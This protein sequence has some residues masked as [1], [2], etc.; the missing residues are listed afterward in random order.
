MPQKLADCMSSWGAWVMSGWVRALLV[1]VGVL[2]GLGGSVAAQV[3]GV[4]LESNRF[5]VRTWGMS[6]GL[7]AP[8]VTAL[9]QTA[10]G[11]IWAASG[12]GLAR[13]DGSRFTVFGSGLVPAP[14]L[15]ATALAGGF[16]DRLWVGRGDGGVTAVDGKEIREVLGAGTVPGGVVRLVEDNR[17]RLW[18][19]GGDG[20]VSVL[21][22]GVLDACSRRWSGADGG[23]KFRVLP[24][25]Q[26]GVLI[27]SSG[28]LWKGAPGPLVPHIPLAGSP[29]AWLCASTEAWRHEGGMVY[30]VSPGSRPE[31]MTNANPPGWCP[32][33]LKMGMA[34]SDGILWVG[35][36]CEGLLAFL[37]DGTRDKLATSTGLGGV[38]VL[39]MMSDRNGHLWVG[40]ENGGLSRI[41]PAIFTRW[42]SR[43]NIRCTEVSSL[44]LMADGVVAAACGDLGVFSLVNA[45]AQPVLRATDGD[46]VIP[47]TTIAPR[48]RGELF[49]GTASDGL[50]Y[51][52]ED[53]AKG[54][55]L[56]PEL[57]APINV[58]LP[59]PDGSILVG[60]KA[61]VPLLEASSGG[62]R[63]IAFKDG[64]SDVR[65]LRRMDDGWLW[66][67]TEEDGLF[68]WKDG[69][70]EAVQAT[71]GG[72]PLGIRSIIP[73][74]DAI[75]VVTART[76]LWRHHGSDLRQCRKSDGLPSDEIIAMVPDRSGAF[77]CSAQ[78][79]FFRIEAEE[80][81]RWFDEGG[82]FPEVTVF[83]ESDGIGGQMGYGKTHQA[84]VSSPDGSL[85]FTS[86][87]GVVQIH[88]EL[89]RRTVP[90]GNII[91]EDVRLNGDVGI[92]GSQVAGQLHR[93]E[94]HFTIPGA[95]HPDGARYEVRLTPF[96]K[97]W[98]PLGAQRSVDYQHLRHGDYVFEVRGADRF[99]QTAGGAQFPFTVLAPVWLRPW[100]WVLSGGVLAGVIHS[101]M[102]TAYLRRMRRLREEVAIAAARQEE[103]ARIAR[104]MHDQLGAGL[105]ELVIIGDELRRGNT[106]SGGPERVASCAREL[107]DEMNDSIWAINPRNDYWHNTVGYLSRTIEEMGRRAGMEVRVNSS[108]GDQDCVLSSSLRQHLLLA[109]REA[110]TNAIRHASATELH[111]SMEHQGCAVE[112]RVEDNGQ[113]FP[114][115]GPQETGNGLRNMRQ[116]MQE[117]GGVVQFGRSSHGGAM[118]TLHV[119]APKVTAVEQ[120]SGISLN[121]PLMN[122]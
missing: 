31:P 105:A 70:A 4:P 103:R 34:G 114:E 16:S 79:G 19:E 108:A 111:V 118:V 98:V 46:R 51:C 10:D 59:G 1:V 101:F 115:G 73:H 52:R 60:R 28:G 91:I 38:N 116:R 107:V 88:P 84:A 42:D 29:D 11:Y 76:G 6:E 100:F 75:W 25:G 83:G 36:V 45:Y 113:G 33:H 119:P 17:G 64:A 15:Q 55:F 57:K 82:S 106:D 14:L 96:D 26:G 18:I 2:V 47:F 37:P 65:A 50:L 102:R 74:D 85:W 62:S 3:A 112:I 53:K 32:R 49:G 22:N 80:L 40:I 30:R 69:T 81:A 99:G 5:L 48:E 77:W 71:G 58:L 20:A 68:R 87:I 63:V 23:Q 12:Q 92:A 72:V 8:S 41:Q 13:F 21:E 110:V 86:S 39:A 61:E 24:D 90:P 44:I 78:S 56:E 94:F 9:A 89:F 7:P 95:A 93:A 104:D 117:V 35:T 97:A 43:R 120:G 121:Q 109:T 54:V 67:G 27:A 66:I 122:S